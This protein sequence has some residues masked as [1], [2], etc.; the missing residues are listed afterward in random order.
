MLLVVLAGCG[1]ALRPAPHV[2]ILMAH[3]ADRLALPGARIP[4]APPALHCALE[5][6]PAPE[7]RAPILAFAR[8]NLVAELARLTDFEAREA[9]VETPGE[10]SGCDDPS[11]A[12]GMFT[13]VQVTPRTGL[14]E[15]TVSQHEKLR[16]HCVWGAS[17]VY[18]LRVIASPSGT[19]V[20]AEALTAAIG[21]IERDRRRSTIADAP[22]AITCR[23]RPIG[24]PRPRRSCMPWRAPRT[25]RLGATPRQPRSARRSP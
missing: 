7:L 10:H 16:G 3:P 21:R 15:V 22:R 19:T 8:A 12:D 17:V 20:I 25:L 18:C 2:R 5:G 11:H 23:R 13:E 14:G 24:G 1:T 4:A 6:A 9:E